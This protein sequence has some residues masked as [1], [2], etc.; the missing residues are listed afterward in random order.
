MIDRVF[1]EH[2]PGFGRAVDLIV[3][4]MRP[5]PDILLQIVVAKFRVVE[6][7]GSGVN[8]IHLVRRGVLDHYRASWLPPRITL[9]D[10][11]VGTGV[12]S[13]LNRPLIVEL[14]SSENSFMTIVIKAIKQRVSGHQIVRSE[15][16]FDVRFGN[17]SPDPY[18]H[19]LKKI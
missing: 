8:G 3:E 11:D 7:V 4:L 6:T 2:V 18:V 14:R 9:P 13:S 1:H 15:L 10:C 5:S 19:S 12:D 16:C 17:D